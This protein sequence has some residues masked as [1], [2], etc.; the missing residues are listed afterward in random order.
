MAESIGFEYVN[1]ETIHYSLKCCI[2]NQPF[3]RPVSTNCKKRHKFCRQCIERWLEGHRTCPKCRQPLVAEDLVSI[4]EDI[5][6]DVLNELKVKCNGCG[7]KG[8]ERGD[9]EEHRKRS[10][11]MIAVSCKAQDIK[12]PWKGPQ[13]ELENHLRTCSFEVL[14]PL[15]TSLINENRELHKQLDRHVTDYQRDL[16]QLQE[17]VQQQ[18]IEIDRQ[19]HELVQMKSQPRQSIN[20]LT[21]PRNSITLSKSRRGKSAEPASRIFEIRKDRSLGDLPCIMT[22]SQSFLP[23]IDSSLMFL[24]HRLVWLHA[25]ARRWKG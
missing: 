21:T 22:L 13:H 12:C 14:R 11:P 23:K 24:C 1:E 3:V 7:Q 15:L 20:R 18:K 16:A 5:V 6:V 4:T 8:I 9:F 17:K 10:C 2:C 25:G 19:K